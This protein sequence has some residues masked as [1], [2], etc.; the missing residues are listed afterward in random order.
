MG[1]QRETLIL[2]RLKYITLLSHQTN[3]TEAKLIKRFNDS[4][5]DNIIDYLWV[6]MAYLF[7]NNHIQFK[8]VIGE[9]G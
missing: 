9:I 5:Y 1:S 4:I 3:N 2:S 6:D 8:K 7:N